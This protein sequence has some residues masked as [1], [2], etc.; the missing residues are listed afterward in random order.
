[1]LKKMRAFVRAEEV[2]VEGAPADDS[3]PVRFVASTEGVKRDGAD[4]RMEDWDLSRYQKHPVVL[5]AHDMMGMNLPIGTG[6]V[7]FS[8]GREMLI[9]VTYDRDDEFAM[10]VRGKALKG[11]IAGS[12]SWDEIKAEGKTVN[13]LLEFSNVPV[14]VDENALPVRSRME[15]DDRTNLI[16]RGVAL[17]MADLY[18]PQVTVSDEER[19][20]LYNGLSRLYARLGRE[21]PEWRTRAE[22]AA[23]G[24]SEYRGLFLENEAEL[25]PAVFGERVGAVLSARNL[26]DLEQAVDLIRG[27]IARAKEDR[28]PKDEDDDEGR[29]LETIL[30][31][32]TEVSGK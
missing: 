19:R 15:T 24:S 4:L 13:Q 27:V 5:W 7:Q 12:V 1:M 16:W 14:G 11:M 3:S 21:A 26:G 20:F 31:R 28:E 29:A 8:E 22:C 30:A 17:A 6:A 18:H 32:I 10:K 2:P 25:L 9:D 23:Y